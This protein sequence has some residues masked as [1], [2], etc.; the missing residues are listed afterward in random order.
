MVPKRSVI[1]DLNFSRLLILVRSAPDC[2]GPF[3]RLCSEIVPARKKGTKK[4]NKRF[5]L[6][7]LFRDESFNATF[8]ILFIIRLTF[9][10]TD[11]SLNRTRTNDIR[12]RSVSNLHYFKFATA[13]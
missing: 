7:K 3:V 11:Q 10:I 5:A 2:P 12:K 9:Y 13:R 1:I 4:K 8:C 6:F